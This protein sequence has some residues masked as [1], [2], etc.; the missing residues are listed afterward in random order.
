MILQLYVLLNSNVLLLNAVLLDNGLPK[1]LQGG[2]GGSVPYNFLKPE[3]RSH[4]I[5]YQLYSG[6]SVTLQ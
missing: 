3:Y 5:M 6:Y 4:I 1:D 2:G